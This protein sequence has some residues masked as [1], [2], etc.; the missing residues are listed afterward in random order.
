MQFCLAGGP[1]LLL[2]GPLSTPSQHRSCD[3]RAIRQFNYRSSSF[4][5]IGGRN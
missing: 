4:A 5:V 2:G 1:R 3:T